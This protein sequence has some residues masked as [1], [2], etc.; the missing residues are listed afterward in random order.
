[1]TKID[2]G[3]AIERPARGVHVTP[4]MKRRLRMTC[5]VLAY[6]VTVLMVCSLV[7][8]ILNGSKP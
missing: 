4:T 5:Y 8:A 6:A 7:I 3:C 1:M 2:Y